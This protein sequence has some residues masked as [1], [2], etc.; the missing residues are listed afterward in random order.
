[1]LFRWFP[2]EW[3]YFC[4]WFFCST[5]LTRT[6]HSHLCCCFFSTSTNWIET[7]FKTREGKKA[8]QRIMKN[9]Y[10]I[11]R[12]NCNVFDSTIC[13]YDSKSGYE[14]HRWGFFGSYQYQSFQMR[15]A[16]CQLH[17]YTHAQRETAYESFQFSIRLMFTSGSSAKKIIHTNTYTRAHTSQASQLGY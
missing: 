3:V 11:L 4:V 2:R 1:M 12:S 16:K 13:S 8:S 17:I 15:N 10:L 9:T 7:C 14:S 6:A 5:L